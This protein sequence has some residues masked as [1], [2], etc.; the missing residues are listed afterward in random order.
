[1]SYV[2]GHPLT[3]A[4]EPLLEYFTHASLNGELSMKDLL[5][6]LTTSDGFLKRLP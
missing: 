6:K 2:F 1:M 4:E 3:Q 5:V